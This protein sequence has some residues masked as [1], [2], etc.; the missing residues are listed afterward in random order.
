MKTIP[1]AFR[2]RAAA[3]I[4]KDGKLLV[5]KHVDYPVYYTVGGGVELGESSEEAV[6]REIWEETGLRLEIDRLAFV[7]ERFLTV[8]GHDC[9]EVVFYY[10]MKP[11]EFDIAEGS[12]TDQGEKES[13]HWL[14][15]DCLD[16]FNLV[17]A[18][19]KTKLRASQ[20][21]IE[22]MITRE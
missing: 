2:Y 14:P 13:L 9:H 22:H 20:G 5:E 10:R 1:H 11:A 18:F 12:F 8:D 3:L 4:V 7:N 21:G 17:P 6:L 15:L 19:L 16:K